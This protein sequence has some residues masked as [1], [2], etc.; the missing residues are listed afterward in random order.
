[1]AERWNQGGSNYMVKLAELTIRASRLNLNKKLD[2]LVG[3]V[4][5]HAP[6]LRRSPDGQKLLKQL[7]QEILRVRYALKG[8]TLP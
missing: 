3:M 7:Q 4:N 5:I 8:E 6:A 1:M 2:S